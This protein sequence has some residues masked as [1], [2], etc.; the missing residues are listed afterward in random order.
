MNRETG[1]GWRNMVGIV[2]KIWLVMVLSE[3]MRY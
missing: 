1:D 2:A 3:I